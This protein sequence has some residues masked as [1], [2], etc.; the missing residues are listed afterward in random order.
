VQSVSPEVQ[1]LILSDPGRTAPQKLRGA[2]RSDKPADHL[3]PVRE[4]G[5]PLGAPGVCELCGRPAR[6]HVLEGY[7]AGRPLRRCFCVPCAAAPSSSPRAAQAR[8]ARLRLRI[9]VGLAG[10]A[11][12]LVGL[13]GDQLIPEGHAG[14]GWYQRIGALIG[15]LVLFIGML[16][17]AEVVVAGGALFLGAALCAD[18]FGLTRGPGIGWKQQTMLAVGGACVVLVLAGRRVAVFSGRAK[19]PP[20]RRLRRSRPGRESEGATDADRRRD[21]ADRAFCGGS[22]AAPAVSTK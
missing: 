21:A 6:V 9:V 5:D 18:W 13:L 20:S 16:V 17:R 11:L 10:V 19:L 12:A 4:T 1:N 14:F 8:P 15:A 3:A 22:S 2:R 7:A